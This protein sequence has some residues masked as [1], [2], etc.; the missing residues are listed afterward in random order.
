MSQKRLA[1]ERIHHE[2]MKKSRVLPPWKTLRDA[3]L[4]KVFKKRE[5]A[6]LHGFMVIGSWQ[7][8]ASSIE[9]D[10]V[11]LSHDLPDVLDPL[12]DE[13]HLA[14]PEQPDDDL[15]IRGRDDALDHLAARHD[16]EFAWTDLDQ[17]H[18]GDRGL[19]D[20]GRLALTRRAEEEHVDG[21]GV[22]EV[23]GGGR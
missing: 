1:K 10:E 21:F 8:E 6:L 5:P 16:E 2:A 19:E 9:N 4:V 13:N 11:R 3:R 12:D 7:S 23:R 22:S 18:F 20:A 17:R 14:R 15:A